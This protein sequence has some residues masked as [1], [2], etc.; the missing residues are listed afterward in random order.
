MRIA[1]VSLDDG[2]A[3]HEGPD[4][5]AA[6]SPAGPHV[7]ALATAMAEAGHAVTVYV[8]AT[9]PGLDPR[10]TAGPGLEVV[11]LPAG[12]PRELASND[13]LEH[14]GEFG[15][16][17]A[18]HWTRHRPDVV[19]AH[20]W[21]AGVAS[22]LAAREAKVPVVQTFQ[23]LGAIGGRRGVPAQRP[24][25]E[26]LVGREAV[27]VA[28]TSSTE[29]DELIRRGVSRAMISV[30]PCG[31]DPERFTPQGPAAERGTRYRLVSVGDLVPHKGFDTTVRALRALPETELVIAGGPAPAEL[32]HDPE[33]R[34]L[35]ALARR[36]G[37]TDRVHLLGRVADAELPALLRSADALVC[38][39]SAEPLGL[40]VLEAM[41]CEVAVVASEVGGLVDM[42][43]DG[44]TGRLV[45]P[46][47]PDSLARALAPLLA[48]P[49]TAQSYGAAGRDRVR[50]RYSWDRVAE[51]TVRVYRQAVG[52][53][54]AL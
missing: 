44:V 28:A 51:D 38:C 27:R 8:R 11:R 42:V 19:H 24:K 43:I 13:L 16:H 54:A 37:V 21:S 15:G 20:Y 36:E 47:D 18:A 26:R 29:A 46:R 17:L 41:A 12:P 32:P 50:A 22:V 25:L 31:V 40:V 33:A 14:L 53:F 34:R 23:A 5:P 2:P 35:F 6:L 48:D 3:G 52:E 10:A 7:A 49:V 9:A 4:R 30:V 1:M 39:P 45:P